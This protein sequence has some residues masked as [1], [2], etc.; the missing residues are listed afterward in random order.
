[1]LYFDSAFIARFYLPDAENDILRATCQEAGEV[2]SCG[3]ALPEVCFALH[4]KWREQEI[5][6]HQ[7]EAMIEQF[8]ED[9]RIGAWVLHPVTPGLC[10]TAAHES[11]RIGRD[12][13]LRSADALHLSCARE[14]GCKAIH[15]NDRHLLAA[16][17]HFG[18]KGINLLG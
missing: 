15:S 6:R 8:N 10:A 17:R 7:F 9:T 14:Q 5:D 4:R 16:A 1:M 13:F 18:L 2:A 11:T 12:T 3:L